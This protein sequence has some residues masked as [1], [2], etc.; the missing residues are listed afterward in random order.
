MDWAR[1]QTDLLY[2]SINF[3]KEKYFLFFRVIQSSTE[4]F[5]REKSARNKLFLALGSFGSKTVW[6]TDLAWAWKLKSEGVQNELNTGYG[7][8]QKDKFS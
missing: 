2:N 1:R 6:E 3:Y 7:L 4:T 5:R 8:C